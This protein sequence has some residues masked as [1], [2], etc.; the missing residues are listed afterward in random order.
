MANEAELDAV[1]AARR[2]D[3]WPAGHPGEAELPRLALEALS[4]YVFVVDEDVR[5]LA[6]NKRAGKLL[7]AGSREVL[8]KR[9][10]EAL[11]CL[12][13]TE[14]PEGCGKSGFCAIRRA[15]ESRSEGCRWSGGR[16]SARSHPA[17][18]RRAAPGPLGFPA[19]LLT[20][21]DSPMARSGSPLRRIARCC[22]AATR[23]G[24][25]YHAAIRLRAAPINTDNSRTAASN[26]KPFKALLRRIGL[27]KQ[28][29]QPKSRGLGAGAAPATPPPLSEFCPKT[30]AETPQLSPR[31]APPLPIPS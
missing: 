1:A 22:I 8:R 9:A 13:A 20:G 25:F 6:Y 17:T 29:Q 19:P 26:P 27:G 7:E 21:S 2:A 11:H 10:G 3:G 24:T 30:T 4:A 28:S 14:S 5:I 23:F 15:L 16:G 31:V 12:H 18:R